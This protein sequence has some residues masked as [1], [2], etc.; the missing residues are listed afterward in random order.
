MRI[1]VWGINYAPEFTGIAPHSVALCE[2]L[3]ARGD[4]VA[5]VTGFSYYPVWQKRPEDHATLYRTD[6]INGVAVHRCWQFVPARVS[7][8]KRIF[9]E[10]SFIFTST[11]RALSLPRPDVYVLV[12]PPLL[13][14]VAGWL[15]GKIKGAP[16]VF[17][18]QDM[19]P[20]AAVGLGMLKASWFTKALYALEAFAYQHAARVSGITQGM[21]KAFRAKGVSESKLLY[22]PNAISLEETEPSPARGEFRERHGFA[23]EEFLA[24]YAGNIGVKQGLDVLLETAPLLRDPRI[25]IVICG[26]G[27]QREFLEQRVRELKLPNVSMLP[28]QKDRDYRALLVDADICFITQQ[29]G[30]GNSFFPS[31]LLGLLAE[32]KPVVTVA[33]AE[34]ELALAVAEGQFGINIPPGYP[35]QLA[36]LLD[37]L[38]QDQERLARFGAAGRRY[39]AQFEKRRVLQKFAE[40][41][42]SLGKA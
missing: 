42:E 38:A 3:Q 4:D 22:F 9:H 27:A 5:M 15:V 8:L 14:G 26:D 2:F 31:K 28:L 40:D 7:A 16:F 33:A 13:L 39:V 24:I 10:A 17:H 21:L 20:D 18:V 25:R 37:S 19:Q 35:E 30:S 36:A 12:S 23:P 41:L 6:L 11:L 34:C 32:S 1:I 29:A